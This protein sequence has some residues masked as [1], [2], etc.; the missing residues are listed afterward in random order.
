VI[1]N[2]Y[3]I[4]FLLGACGVALF[5]PFLPRVVRPILLVIVFACGIWGVFG[6]QISHRLAW[7]TSKRTEHISYPDAEKNAFQEG[8]YA[9][10]DSAKRSIPVLIFSL[11]VL[12]AAAIHG[13]RPKPNQALERTYSAEG[14]ANRDE[15]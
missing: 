14:A 6:I 9:A 1:E 8:V 13:G 5:L 10:S 2:D 12:T 11:L 3:I 15:A 7:Y 4:L